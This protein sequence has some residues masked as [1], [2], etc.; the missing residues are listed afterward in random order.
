MSPAEEKMLKLIPINGKIT[1]DKLAKKFYG[2]NVPFNGR[3]IIID[4][5]SRL[6]RQGLIDRGMRRGPYPLEVWRSFKARLNR[7]G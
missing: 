5:L 7:V 1:T 2:E 6:Y 3:K 4:I